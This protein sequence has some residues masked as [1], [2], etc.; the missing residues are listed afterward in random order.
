MSV[1]LVEIMGNCIMDKY[2]ALVCVVVLQAIGFVQRTV[3]VTK[4]R[5][6]GI[7]WLFCI[8][9]YHKTWQMK[10]KTGDPGC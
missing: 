2:N 9:T 8:D 5:D 10:N 7:L 6:S 3:I 1:N 4:Y